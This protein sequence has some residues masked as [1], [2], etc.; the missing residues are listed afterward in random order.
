[1]MNLTLEQLAVVRQYAALLDTVEEGFTYVVESF[2]NYERTQG[3]VVLADIFTA[4]G[5]IEAT[6][7][8]SLASFFAEDQ[9]IMV[10]IERFSAVIDEAWKLDGKLDDQNAKQHIVENYLAPA[11]E[12]WKTNIMDHL[13]QYVEQ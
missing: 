6:N 2:H 12:A 9:A 7:K 10:E 5:Q 1:M 8:R 13:R 11:F 3:D 4:F